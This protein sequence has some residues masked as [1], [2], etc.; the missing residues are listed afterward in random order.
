MNTNPIEDWYEAVECPD[1]IIYL[2]D[3]ELEY[4]Q[5]RTFE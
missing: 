4:L 2:T 5:R 3:D 1:P